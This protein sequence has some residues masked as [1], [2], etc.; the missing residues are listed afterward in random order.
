[1]PKEQ[2]KHFVYDFHNFSS[3]TKVQEK[4]KRVVVL[5]SHPRQKVKLGTFTLSR[6]SRAVTWQRNVQ[7][8]VRVRA[9]TCKVVVLL[10]LKALWKR[11]QH[12]WPTTPN[13][14]GCYMLRPFAHP[15]PCHC[16]LLEVFVQSLNYVQTEATKHC[17]PVT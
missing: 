6:C 3:L 10:T 11:T 5:C 14:A 8:S 4:K 2:L 15:V 13:N 17:W 1:M 7:K 12:C 9:C 16:E